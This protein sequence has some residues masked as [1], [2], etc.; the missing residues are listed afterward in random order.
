MVR[1]SR[2]SA[3]HLH[4]LLAEHLAGAVMG[5]YDVV[6]QLEL[7]VLD[8]ARDLKLLDQLIFNCLGNGVLLGFATSQGAVSQVCR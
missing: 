6:A 8:L 3:E 4:L 7:D 1:Y 2:H 5:V